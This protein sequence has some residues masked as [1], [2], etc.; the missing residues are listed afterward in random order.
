MAI[1]EWFKINGYNVIYGSL[2]LDPP[3]H[4]LIFIKLLA[5]ASISRVPGT[6]CIADNIPYPV[7]VLATT[8]GVTDQQLS[9][10]IKH[11][12][13]AEQARIKIND[14]GGI[15]ILKWAH[16]Q[17]KS[18]ERVRKHR[19]KKRALQQRKKP[20]CNEDVT[21]CNENVTRRREE[22][23]I[24]K[25]IK[26]TSKEKKRHLDYVLLTNEENQKLIDRFGKTKTLR[27]IEHLNN[28]IGSKGKK[29]KSHYHTIL[30]WSRDDDK[31]STTNNVAKIFAEEEAKLKQKNNE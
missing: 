23:R 27:K 28:Y 8:L 1:M 9:D 25:T 13:D 15:E 19:K 17:S 16:Y 29:Y 22:N 18:Y 11:H 30:N 4:Q 14:W 10:A 2:R 31:S 6:I 24:E 20:N 26:K 5:M 12:T 7:D 21:L 3:M